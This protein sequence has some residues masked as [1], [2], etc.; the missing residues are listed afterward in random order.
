[1]FENILVAT[2]GSSN[3]ERAAAV[4]GALAA[5]CHAKLS[6]VHVAPPFLPLADVTDS[7]IST[8]F[9][10]DV[11][12][13]IQNL[14]EQTGGWEK[15]PFSQIPA[16]ESAVRYVCGVA[17]GTAERIARENGAQTI[18]QVIADGDPANAIVAEARRINADLIVIGSR[19]LGNLEG[20]IIGSVSH[21]VL[22][23]SDCP[24]VTVK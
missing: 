4:A 20:L 23:L 15:T 13:D 1:M 3:A 7:A 12:D 14:L 19:G 17:T 10:K 2:D 11:R 6:I 5:A 24:C 8:Q 18:E 9:P 22:L 16:P 21:K